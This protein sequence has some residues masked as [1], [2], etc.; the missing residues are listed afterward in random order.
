ML[1]FFRQI[2]QQLMEQNKVRSYFLYAF[3]EILLV[4]IGILIALQ[5]NNW[6]EERKASEMKIGLLVSIQ[7]EL[8]TDLE[9]VRLVRSDIK[10]KYDTGIYMMSYFNSDKDVSEFDVHRL[11]R[12]LMDSNDIQEFSPVQL[13][14]KE[15][16]STGIVNRIKDDS[17]KQM[18]FDHYEISVREQGEFEQRD[19]YGTDVSESRFDYIPNLTLV[20]KV[21]TIFQQGDWKE[22]PYEDLN[23]DWNKIRRD[24]YFPM[25]L[26]RL[27]AVQLA[28]IADMDKTESNIYLMMERINKEIEAR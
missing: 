5:V 16:I 13:G 20:E 27:L 3:G 10:S 15:L 28:E 17:L 18:L 1:R 7:Q 12:G 8:Q 22:N 19:R 24:G 25:F 11:R 23:P 9:L 4:V 21:K 2:R 6:N 26:G 14:Y